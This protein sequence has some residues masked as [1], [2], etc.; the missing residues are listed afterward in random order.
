M[1]DGYRALVLQEQAAADLDS[2]CAKKGKFE[3]ATKHTRSVQIVEC[4]YR[5]PV[6]LGILH[7]HPWGLSTLTQGFNQRFCWP[8]PVSSFLG[9]FCKSLIILAGSGEHSSC[10]VSVPVWDVFC[11]SLTHSLHVLVD[12]PWEGPPSWREQWLFLLAY[13][14]LSNMVAELSTPLDPEE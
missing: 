3:V 2:S 4:T 12:R 5:A 10:R 11:G 9:L 1:T 7:R 8:Q 6:G 13:I 14:Q